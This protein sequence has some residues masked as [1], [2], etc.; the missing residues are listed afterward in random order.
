MHAS[1]PA[2]LRACLFFVILLAAVVTTV[3]RAHAENGDALDDAL[4][5]LALNIYFEARGEPE[6]GRLAVGHV[7]LNRVNDSRFPNT[8]CGVI[9]DG[10][11]TT[12]HRCQF[13]WWCDGKSDEPTDEAA[14]AASQEAAQKVFWAL[15]PDLTGGA[16][17]YH[18]HYVDPSWRHRFVKS[19]VIG[20][21]VFYQRPAQVASA[22]R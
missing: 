5:C 22:R 4:H 14:W 15:A 7:V 3:S 11:E 6:M 10:G 16:L 8:V 1:I 19:A 2:R 9:K 20:Q 13:S 17:W 18:A 21:H 12:L